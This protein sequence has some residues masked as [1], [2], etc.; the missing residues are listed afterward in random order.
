VSN[1]SGLTVRT[2]Q[3]HCLLVVKIRRLRCEAPQFLVDSRNHLFVVFGL[4]HQQ[5]DLI[6]GNDMV[7]VEMPTLPPRETFF[8][9]QVTPESLRARSV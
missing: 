7:E 9:P 1:Q 4:L 2:E 3:G 8:N 6:D 5:F